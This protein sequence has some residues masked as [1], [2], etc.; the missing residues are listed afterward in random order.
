MAK[1]P[2]VPRPTRSDEYEIVFAS[3]AAAK[4]W[5][6]LVAA[7]RNLMVDAWDFLTRTPHAVTPKNYPLKGTLGT[8]ALVAFLTFL[9]WTKGPSE[10]ATVYSLITAGL[11]AVL[12]GGF[13]LGLVVSWGRRAVPPPMSGEWMT[14]WQ[15][16]RATEPPRRGVKLAAFVF[17]MAWVLFAAG[18]RAVAFLRDL[19]PGGGGL[20]Q[21]AAEGLGFSVV[22]LLLAAGLA[23]L[24]TWLVLRHRDRRP[25]C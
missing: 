3:N 15:G 6:D 23:A 17:G 21:G 16:R 20:P 19:L 11:L 12:V 13:A 10:A 14:A 7:R 1:N 8:V 2:R 18:F 4:G 24:G 5:R 9:V 25:R 22:C